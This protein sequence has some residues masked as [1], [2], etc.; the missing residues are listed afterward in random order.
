MSNRLFGRQVIV[1][2]DDQRYDQLRVDFK[3]TKSLDTSANE[4]EITIYNIPFSSEAAARAQSRDTLIRLYAGYDTPSLIF[5]G[6]PIPNG[7]TYERTETDRLLKIEAKDGYKFYKGTRIS[8]SFATGTSFQDIADTVSEQMGIPRGSIR[9]PQ[10]RS[11]TSGVVLTG[12]P[13]TV[14]RRLA[15]ATGTS[16]SVQDG[17]LQILQKSGANPNLAPLYSTANRNLIS[18]SNTDY[19]VELTVLL[20]NT[21]NPGDRFKIEHP[22][23]SGAFKA[24]KVVYEGSRWSTSFYCKI[25]GVPYLT[26]PPP[27]SPAARAIR[28][29]FYDEFAKEQLNPYGDIDVPE[30]APPGPTR[31]RDFRFFGVEADFN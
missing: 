24:R 22:E 23:F 26:S 4:A 8:A 27:E 30:S 1:S 11:L 25:E 6:N 15:D 20:D 14:L 9:V 13:E 21:L 7:V 10:E 29:K 18:Y 17:S 31:D 16:A 2:I 19:G 5:Q 3:V 28:E 12:D